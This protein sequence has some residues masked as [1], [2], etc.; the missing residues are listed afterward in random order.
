MMPRRDD[1]NQL[2]YRLVETTT[3]GGPNNDEAL[4][5]DDDAACDDGEDAS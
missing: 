5:A 2:A 4:P 3:E 1:L